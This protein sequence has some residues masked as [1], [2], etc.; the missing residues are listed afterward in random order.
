MLLYGL[1]LGQ[2]TSGV[3]YYERASD[4][5]EGSG[6]RRRMEELNL[7]LGLV[8]RWSGRAGWM[9]VALEPPLLPPLAKVNW[10]KAGGYI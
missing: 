8:L 1:A 6:M 2:L 9:N 10:P 3:I 4:L 5:A 7:T